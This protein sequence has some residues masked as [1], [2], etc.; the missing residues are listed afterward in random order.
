MDQVKLSQDRSSQVAT[1]QVKSEFFF[2]PKYFW[3]QIIF[4][5]PNDFLVF[6]AVFK[7]YIIERIKGEFL[8]KVILKAMKGDPKINCSPILVFDID[9]SIKIK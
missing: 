9:P 3:I 6:Q 7:D 8:S 1:G 2:D 4:C 5:V